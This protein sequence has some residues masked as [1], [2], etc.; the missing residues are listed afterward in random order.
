MVAFKVTEASPMSGHQDLY[1]QW[2][3]GRLPQS[4]PPACVIPV[5]GYNPVPTHLGQLTLE[6][7]WPNAKTVGWGAVVSIPDVRG[8]PEALGCRCP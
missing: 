7:A 6:T 3:G 4:A 5:Q 8:S 2:S 1:I